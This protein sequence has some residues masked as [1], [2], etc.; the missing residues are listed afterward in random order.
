MIDLGDYTIFSD[1]PTTLKEASVD[2]R[3]PTT[4]S[5]MTESLIKAVDLD[6]VKNTYVR[7]LSLSSVPSIKHPN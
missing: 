7:P 5:F 6:E 1:N 3:D 4:V 2:R